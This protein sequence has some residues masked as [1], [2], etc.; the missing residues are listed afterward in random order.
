[1]YTYDLTIHLLKYKSGIETKNLNSIYLKMNLRIN[2][3]YA[4]LIFKH[5]FIFIAMYRT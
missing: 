2:I 4:K 1:M 3:L 5:A